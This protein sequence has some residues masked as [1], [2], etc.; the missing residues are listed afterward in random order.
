MDRL[1][2]TI[3]TILQKEPI[4]FYANPT[5]LPDVIA[6]DHDRLWTAERM[7]RVVK[8]LAKNGVA[9]EI[10]DRLRLPRPALIKMAKQAGVKFTFGTNNRDRALSRLDYCVAMV[11]ECA[12]TPDDFWA[13]K[14]DGKKPIQV[15]AGRR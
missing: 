2:Q 3:E 1:V 14:P 6:K 15:R 7:K 8:A 10:N 12:L 5:Y 9:L 13:P 4:D 11:E